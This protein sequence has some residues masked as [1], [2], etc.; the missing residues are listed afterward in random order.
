[1]EVRHLAR[2][3]KLRLTKITKGCCVPRARSWDWNTALIALLLSTDSIQIRI[4]EAATWFPRPMTFCPWRTV[5]EQT[6]RHPEAVHRRVPR[7]AAG[8][9]LAAQCQLLAAQASLPV[10][11]AAPG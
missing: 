4:G 1:M 3:P 9:I 11:G 10:G 5:V 2:G 7:W 8:T 6:V